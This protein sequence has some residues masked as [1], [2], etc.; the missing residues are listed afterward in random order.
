[1][2]TCPTR[3]RVVNEEFDRQWR[4]WV[5]VHLGQRFVE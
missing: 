3:F 2:Y 5:A 1:L 4:L